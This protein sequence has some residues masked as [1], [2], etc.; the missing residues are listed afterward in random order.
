MLCLLIMST[1]ARPPA[2]SD[3]LH[4]LYREHHGWLHAWLRRQL[5]CAQHAADVAHDTFLRILA[6]R[7]ALTAMKE[8]RAYLTTTARRL[9]ID[10][11]RRRVIEQAYLAE[12]A[13]AGIACDGYPSPERTLEAVQALVQL[14]V[15]LQCVSPRAR[16]AFLCHYLD[17][18]P[19]QAIA[20]RLGVSTRMVHKYLAQ[21]LVQ[22]GGVA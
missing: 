1:S 7:D 19:Q 8:P 13:H 12:L 11:A 16:E 3:A 2:A 14:S 22:C 20:L 4:A 21:V 5:G 6:A 15:I 17:G 18:E 10:D 9:M